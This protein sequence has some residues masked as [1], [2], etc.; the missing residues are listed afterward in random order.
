MSD[1]VA[2]QP[3]LM[4]WGGSFMMLLSMSWVGRRDEKCLFGLDIPGVVI[5]VCPEQAAIVDTAVLSDFGVAE[6]AE[7]FAQGAQFLK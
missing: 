3:L 1:F 6:F 5:R 7:Y 4:H 2:G